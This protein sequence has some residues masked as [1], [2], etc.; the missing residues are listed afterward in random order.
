MIR[1]IV[2]DEFVL[3]QKSVEAKPEDLTVLLDLID[4][5]KTHC[6][7]CIG[8][9]A[10]MIGVLRRI[11]VVKDEDQYIGLINPVILKT[12]GRY[13]EAEEGCLCYEGS[14]KT[15]R[16]EKIKVQYRDS[17]WKI[18]IKTFN[19]YVAEAIQHEIDHCNG[20]LI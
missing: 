8:M 13:Y 6:D 1:K 12:S 15:K 18:K 9:A 19:G 5:I 3:C 11:I 20:V 17:D 14:K 16:Y 10:N 4:T 7:E 2:K